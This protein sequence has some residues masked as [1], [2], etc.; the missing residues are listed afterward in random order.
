MTPPQPGVGSRVVVAGPYPTMQGPEAAATFAL[1]RALVAAGDDVTVVSPVPSAAHHHLDVVGARGALGL[2]RLAAGAD[3][4]VVRL[5]AR[6]VGASSDPPRALP[7]RL[8]LRLALRRAGRAEVHLDRV[9]HTLSRRWVSLVLAPAARIVV[10]SASEGEALVAA[11][12][13]P[14]RVAVEQA[15]APPGGQGAA[16]PGAPSSPAPGQLP[17][18]EPEPPPATAADFEALLRRRVARQRSVAPL[19]GGAAAGRASLPLRHLPRMQRAPV[20]SNKAGGA[21]LKR[22]LAKLLAWQFDWVIQ[23]VNQL[24]QAAIDALDGHERRHPNEEETTS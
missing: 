21:L 7:G 2:A 19:P 3:R 15:A 22:A 18:D 10:G 12:V 11:G 14:A 9:P 5:D 17:G 20:R 16:S 23:H 1:V 4:L 8:A 24:H 6:A 13:E